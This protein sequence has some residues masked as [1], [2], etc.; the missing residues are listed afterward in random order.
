MTYTKEQATEGISKLITDYEQLKKRKTAR[1]ERLEDIGEANV[2]ADFIDPLFEILGWNVRNPDEYDRENYVRGA[3]FV[4]IALKLSDRSGITAED[5]AKVFIEAKRFGGVPNL[6]DRTFQK[7]LLGKT[8]YADW[9]EEERQILN[10]ASKTLDVKWAILT[11]FEKFRLFN[12]RT[13]V[14]VLNIEKPEE[15]LERIDELL[16]L[17]KDSIETDRIDI[18]ETRIERPDVDIEF[19]DLM[20][21]WRL[22]IAKS[23]Y[24]N[25]RNKTFEVKGKKITLSFNSEE[26]REKSL[27]LINEATQRIL[28]R[29]IIVK[30]AEDKFVIDPE[31]LEEANRYWKRTSYGSLFVVLN[32]FFRGFWGSHDS[33]IFEPDHICEKVRVNDKILSNIIDGICGMNFRKFTSD[34]LGNTYES[35]LGHELY[36]NESEE[37]NIRPSQQLKK[38]EGIYYTPSYVVNY[39]VK[40]TVGIKLE[41]NWNDVEKLL[42]E[43]EYKEAYNRFKDVS[44]IKVVDP[45]CGSGSFLVKA[46]NLIKEYYKRYNEKIDEIQQIKHKEFVEKKGNQLNLEEERFL[47][48]IL[49]FEKQ[50]L[51][52][53]IYSVDIDP[54]AC[55]IASV[56]LMLQ[57]L[58]SGEKLPLIL[59][60]N[61]K[62]GNSFVSG[63]TKDLEAYFKDVEKE[64]T[65]NWE[66]EFKDIFLDDGFGVVIGNPPWVSFGLRGVEKIPEDM[67]KY[68]RDKYPS[69]AEY[70]LSVFAVFM[71]RGIYLLKSNGRFGFI[72]PDSFLLGRYF[73][74]L[75]RYILNT[76]KIA[77]T[78]LILEDFWKYGTIG[79]SVIILLEK[80][81]DEATRRNN[82]VVVRLC[83]TL[84]DLG[85]RNFKTYSYR[86][87]YFESVLHNRFRLFFDEESKGLV[88]QVELSTI[89]LNTLV[90]IYSGCIGRY[91]QDSIISDHKKDEMVIKNKK[92]DV[93]YE[94]KNAKENWEPL[95]ESGGDIRKYSINYKGK[96]IYFED[97][98]VKRSIYAKSGFEKE[99]YIGTKLF[100]RQTG[101]SLISTYDPDGYFCINN[102]HVINIKPPEIKYNLRYILAII[103]SKL[104]NHYYHLI[105]LEL[106]RAMAQTDIETIEQLPIREINFSNQ[107]EKQIHDEMVKLVDKMITLNKQKNELLRIFK[108]LI[109]KFRQDEEFKPLSDYYTTKKSISL[110]DYT[111]DRAH[112]EN[113][114][115][116]YRL[117]IIKSQELIDY[118]EEGKITKIDCEEKGNFL[119]LRVRLEGEKDFRELLKIYFEDELMMRFFH[120]SI[121]TY[122][123]EKERKKYWSKERIWEVLDEIK[124]PRS[125][126]NVDTDAR[127]IKQL[128]KTFEEA[129]MEKLSEEFKESPVKELNLTKIEEEIEKTDNQIDQK[130]YALYGLAEEE[131]GIIEKSV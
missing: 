60:E 109:K 111:E 63:S 87:E 125:V 131:I 31:Q 126:P 97:D 120:F 74:K 76:T 117:N 40:N 115:N 16:F 86:Q 17:T 114:I 5:K 48:K 98:A 28:D 10:Y 64:K 122:L 77:E 18:L 101:D 113:E 3:G 82:M 83:P 15:L 71:N 62:V 30:Y 130:V 26:E 78:V 96:Y 84:N 118:K 103:N 95:L 41:E 81:D 22:K 106:G 39:I 32:D 70:K 127:N 2:R 50:I 99:K 43:G 6:T 51:K 55:E 57:A 23:I 90:D 13:G 42:D 19:L 116:K 79:R 27:E 100:L 65:F 73:S 36:F 121:K 108:D 104:M 52:D 56:N 54:S 14:T 105:S 91:G 75:R 58:K 59:D 129:Y 67:A 33:K 37:L 88:D 69:S 12:A 7:T 21:T 44:K 47:T 93:V 1:K 61:I 11:N 35:Y 49:N 102:M 72:V 24:E 4:D 128:M 20:N 38:S 34:I 110:E 112:R 89:A 123:L 119:I 66:K 107:K 80:E 8:I 9:T 46:F 29:L 25:N 92:G 45:A 94:D 124:I 53:N 68:L 85:D